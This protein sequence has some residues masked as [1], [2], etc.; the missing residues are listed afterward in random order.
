[1]GLISGIKSIGRGITK[2][3]SKIPIFGGI[4]AGG[5]KF[6]GKHG[7]TIAGIGLT[8]AAIAGTGGIAAG[9]L[10]ALATR[11]PMLGKLAASVGQVGS[12]IASSGVG[13]SLATTFGKYFGSQSALGGAAQS[14]L[15][16]VR[17]WGS[18]L[19]STLQANKHVTA[20]RG[21]GSGQ[22][23]KA[24]AWASGLRGGGK[25]AG[26]QQLSLFDDATLAA[27]K[28]G[29]ATAA[30]SGAGTASAGM[31]AMTAAPALM[32]LPMMFNTPQMPNQVGMQS[33]PPLTGDGQ[34]INFET[35]NPAAFV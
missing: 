30:A 14:G 22:A 15:S 8:V 20:A 34:Q 28:T 10:A 6:L 26:P 5:L 19:S 24:K 13:R 4:A 32:S 1:M 23:S 35:F 27:T 17:G 21:W 9:P 3:V 2:A 18:N 33:L 29:G 12:K 11:F 31:N 7:L 25:A 16:T